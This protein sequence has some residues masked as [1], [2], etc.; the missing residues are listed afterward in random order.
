MNASDGLHHAAIAVPQA[1]AVN[2]LQFT[3]VGAAVLSDGDAHFPLQ[4]T[5]H[6][7]GPD[8]F[9][10]HLLI[11]KAMGNIQMCHGFMSAGEY[12]GN[13]FQQGFGIIGGNKRVRQRGTG[14]LWVRFLADHTLRRA[15]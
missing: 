7:A 5:G 10:V 14:A 12:L 2:M 6:G 13:K 8:Q 9:V 11:S 4:N 15:T 3:Q 1:M